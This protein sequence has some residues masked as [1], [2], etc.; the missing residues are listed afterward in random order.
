MRFLVV[1]S[2]FLEG[3]D[4]VGKMATGPPLVTMGFH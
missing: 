2:K 3:E 4:W 1:H